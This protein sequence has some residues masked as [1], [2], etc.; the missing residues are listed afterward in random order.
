ME[1]KEKSGSGGGQR[2]WPFGRQALTGDRPSPVV[3]GG[4]P[5]QDGPVLSNRS[6]SHRLRGV[7]DI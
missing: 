7:W 2:S 4:L 6:D 3:L 5:D 1:V